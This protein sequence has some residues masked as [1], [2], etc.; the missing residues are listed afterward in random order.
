[1]NTETGKRMAE[2]RTIYMHEFVNEFL[3]EW[4][5]EK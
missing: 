4:N 2:E 1:M 3:A 5:G